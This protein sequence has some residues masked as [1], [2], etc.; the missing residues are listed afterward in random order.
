MVFFVTVAVEFLPSW[1]VVTVVLLPSF[2]LTVT[3]LVPS[4]LTSLLID[5]PEVLVAVV[6]ILLSPT[7]PLLTIVPLLPVKVAELELRFNEPSLLVVTITS[8]EA[9]TF[10]LV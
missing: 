4:V 8:S 2:L 1:L 3:L 7:V 5:P 10:P 9:L 6:S